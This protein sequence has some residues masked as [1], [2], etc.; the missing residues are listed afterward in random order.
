MQLSN[1]DPCNK[2]RVLTSKDKISK[3][4]ISGWEEAMARPRGDNRML[5]EVSDHGLLYS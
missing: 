4:E 1:T 2:V 3:E 5:F